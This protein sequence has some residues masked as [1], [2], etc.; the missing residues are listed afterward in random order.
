MIE[1][2]ADILQSSLHFGAQ[3]FSEPSLKRER[4]ALLLA[5]NDVTR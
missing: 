1:Q 4:E 3:V 5:V 2:L